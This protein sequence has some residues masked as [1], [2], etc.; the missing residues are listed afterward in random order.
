MILL[1][2]FREVQEVCGLDQ[3][4][5]LMMQR[6]DEHKNADGTRNV[7]YVAVGLATPKTQTADECD[8]R[9]YIRIYYFTAVTNIC[10]S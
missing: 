8:G 10:H 2:F 4:G 1:S 6:D 9:I 5:A 7:R 3:G